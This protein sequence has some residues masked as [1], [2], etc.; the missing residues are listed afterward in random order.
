MATKTIYLTETILAQAEALAEQDQRSLS[1]L[2]GFLVYQEWLRRQRMLG[3]LTG[4][5][6]SMTPSQVRELWNK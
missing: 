5:D 1:N 6:G 3:T 4:A 2:V